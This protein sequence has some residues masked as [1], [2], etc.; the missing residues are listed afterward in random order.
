MKATIGFIPSKI[1]NS[2]KTTNKNK[3]LIIPKE[4]THSCA[5]GQTGCGKTTSY[6]Y[7]N[8][9]NRIKENHGLIV[10]DYKAKEHLAVKS[11]ANKY[12]RFDDIIEIGKQW[13]E[14]INIIK[15]M[16][17]ADLESYLGEL[18]SLEGENRYWGTSAVNI[19]VTILELIEV[20]AKF[21]KTSKD[22]DTHT[23]FEKV[24]KDFRLK[25]F[26]YKK[27]LSSLF[28]IVSSMETLRDFIKNLPSFMNFINV[29]VDNEINKIHNISSKKDIHKKYDLLYYQLEILNETILKTQEK[30]DVFAKTDKNSSRT[31]ES[32]ILSMNTPLLS[33]ADMQWLNE[34]KFDIIKEINNGKII[35]INSKTFSDTMLASF[36]NSL[37]N[38]LSKRTNFPNIKPVSIFVDEAQRVFSKYTDL[39]IDIF[40]EAKV[41]LFLA[42]QNSELMIE[43]LGEN[44]YLALLQN[45]S[46]KYIFKNM[47]FFNDID[48]SKFDTFEY[49][50]DENDLKDKLFKSE[51]IFFDKNELFDIELKYQ[52][53]IKLHE[54]FA[55][56]KKD[57]NKIII[58]DEHLLKNMQ[59]LLMDK[60]E[61]VE[62]K[63]YLNIELLSKA[64]SSLD[65]VI[66][67]C[68]NP[69][70]INDIFTEDSIKQMFQ[71]KLEGLTQKIDIL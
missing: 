4:Y 63:E 12:D 3:E 36:S 22:I 24:Y 47:G 55:L 34:D 27:N 10:F 33:I 45:L 1:K 43:K 44:K 19:S 41:D 30:L 61:K 66:H 51:H 16:S 2:T 26:P 40:R 15:Y 32:I 67:R 64:K 60:N 6:I 35:I 5:I 8:M 29:T 71:E 69:I 17:K 52:I 37:F 13:G 57:K 14:S 39:P 48:T 21:L 46:E 59:V 68:K 25:G 53:K 31:Y 11:F 54:Q 50:Q 38:E 70:D 56:S 9:E 23:D 20:A 42:F 62:I 18:F 49:T 58:H 65:R 28:S 7:P